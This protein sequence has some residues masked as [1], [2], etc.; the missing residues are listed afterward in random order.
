MGRTARRLQRRKDAKARVAAEKQLKTLEPAKA[1][2][3][4]AVSARNAVA[5]QYYMTKE[6][7]TA[8]PDE[9]PGVEELK[10][11]LETFEANLVAATLDVL[12]AVEDAENAEPSRIV[13]PEGAGELTEGVAL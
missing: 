13:A 7:L 5:R 11:R 3:L 9:T 2:M 6:T 4:E 8:V 1:V 12:D 10:E